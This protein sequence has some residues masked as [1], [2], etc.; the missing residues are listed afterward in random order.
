[1]SQ[2]VGASG[3]IWLNDKNT[4]SLHIFRY[5]FL[6]EW[7][8]VISVKL[9]AQFFDGG[10]FCDVPVLRFQW[11]KIVNLPQDNFCRK[12]CTLRMRSQGQA[13][14]DLS[15]AYLAAVAAC[16]PSPLVKQVRT[17]LLSGSIKILWNIIGFRIPS[18]WL[19]RHKSR[20]QADI[21][22]AA[23]KLR[24]RKIRRSVVHVQ[25]LI[26]LICGFQ[27]SP[28]VLIANPPLAICLHARGLETMVS[29]VTNA[30]WVSLLFTLR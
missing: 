26:N 1:M 27:M 25:R 2:R 15:A 23:V 3:S 6:V 28:T 13:A 12:S 29:N 16:L 8:N 17:S 10:L 22:K 18:E 21:S 20:K 19:N 30:K 5:F 9:S 7:L 4:C 24:C 11:Q 14:W